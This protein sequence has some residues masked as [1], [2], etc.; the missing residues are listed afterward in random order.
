MANAR[1]I[2]VLGKVERTNLDVSYVNAYFVARSSYHTARTK[3]K[4]F[5]RVLFTMVCEWPVK[6]A[7]HSLRLCHPLTIT[8]QSEIS[9]FLDFSCKK[10]GYTV[11]TDKLRSIHA[12]CYNYSTAGNFA[13]VSLRRYWW[14]PDILRIKH[15]ITV[16]YQFKFHILNTEILAHKFILIPHLTSSNINVVSCEGREQIQIEIWKSVL[17]IRIVKYNVS[18]VGPSSER[19]RK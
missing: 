15:T 8:Q 9:M 3:M 2:F 5:L 10:W 6:W 17:P 13:V 19:N 7:I 11:I 18:S 16:F 4:I 14:V 12:I 1:V